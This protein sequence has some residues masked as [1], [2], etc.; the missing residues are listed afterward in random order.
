[1][2]YDIHAIDFLSDDVVSKIFGWSLAKVFDLII[3]ITLFIVPAHQQTDL[4]SIG[5]IL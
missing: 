2:E 3:S 5:I 1:M 4:S